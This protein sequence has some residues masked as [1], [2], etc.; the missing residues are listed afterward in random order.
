MPTKLTAEIINAA[1]VGFEQQKLR[2]DTQIA[3]LRAAMLSGGATHPTAAKP[4][5]TKGKRRKMSAAARKRIGDA[6]RKRWAASKGEAESPSK[7]ATPKPKRKMSAAGK[8]AI[9]EA[10]KKRW[11]AF[12]ATKQAKKPAAKKAVA[13]TKLSPAR[14]AALVA[15]LAKARAAKA[16]KV[17]AGAQ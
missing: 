15:N 9:S 12:H 10:T 17:A 11:A 13:R 2:I 5:P 14:K 4:E 3:E 1:I 6:Q 7:T 8:K 16:A